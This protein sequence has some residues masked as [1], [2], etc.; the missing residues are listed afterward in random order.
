MKQIKKLGYPT[1]EVELCFENHAKFQA[2]C[3]EY[4]SSM[5]Y[6]I[7]YYKSRLEQDRSS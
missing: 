5:P 6:L 4:D 3:K 1:Y 2:K 7:S